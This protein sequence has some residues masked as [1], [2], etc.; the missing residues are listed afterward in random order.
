[1]ADN[2][3]CN[4]SDDC[5]NAVTHIGDGGYIYCAEHAKRRR[6]AGWE[7]TRKMRPWE[8][9]WIRAGCPLP[10]YK[11][12]PEPDLAAAAL[13]AAEGVLRDLDNVQMYGPA[14]RIRESARRALVLIEDARQQ[15]KTRKD[16]TC[17]TRSSD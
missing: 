1:M 6:A 3:Q 4:M 16:R 7:R 15:P 2:L 13:D 14:D 11:P 9:R 17:M 10:D 8:L 12:G 5:T